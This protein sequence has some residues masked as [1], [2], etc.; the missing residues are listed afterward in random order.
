MQTDRVVNSI[1][2]FLCC[3]HVTVDLLVRLKTIGGVIPIQSLYISITL[4]SRPYSSGSFSG[5]ANLH[6]PEGA[7]EL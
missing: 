7:E 2:L 1:L 4:K 3:E 6:Y 5:S